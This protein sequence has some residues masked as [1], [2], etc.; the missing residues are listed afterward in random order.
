MRVRRGK[1][2]GRVYSKNP[3]V[4]LQFFVI[5]ITLWI[6]KSLIR[7][8]QQYAVESSDLG[9]IS[10]GSILCVSRDSAHVA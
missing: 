7:R 9:R 8:I 10:A 2:E 5:S 4:M 1:S 3:R 6:G